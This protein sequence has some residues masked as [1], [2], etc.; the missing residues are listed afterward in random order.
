MI[1]LEPEE[2][3]Y[4][5]IYLLRSVGTEVSVDVGVIMRN[6]ATDLI[7]FPIVVRRLSTSGSAW[8]SL[9]MPS[10]SHPHPFGNNNT[11]K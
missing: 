11:P 7:P 8:L 6:N 4:L 1:V 9:L 2:D 3:Y 5:S 10:I